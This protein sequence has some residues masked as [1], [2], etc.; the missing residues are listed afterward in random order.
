MRVCMVYVLHYIRTPP[1]PLF[2]S[3]GQYTQ[4]AMIAH[5][6][7][8]PAIRRCMRGENQSPPQRHL[9]FLPKGELMSIPITSAAFPKPAAPSFC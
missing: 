3:A 7:D 1:H 6:F 9:N 5:E 2:S 4:T 8:T